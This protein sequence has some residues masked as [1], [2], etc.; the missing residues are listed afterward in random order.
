MST[1][2]DALELAR[3]LFAAVE[4]GDIEAVRALYADDAVVWHN[5][6]GVA[7]TGDENL[8]TLAW[9]VEHLSDRRYEEITCQPT[10]TGF[11][12][13]HVLRATGPAGRPVEVP[14]CLVAAVVDGKITRIDEYLD[15]AHLAS[16]FDA[17]AQD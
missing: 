17:P 7:Q 9:V 4:A 1:M 11:V 5:T 6:D 15:S 3:R 14:A 12:Q 16:L 8:R 2:P 10:P 13:Q